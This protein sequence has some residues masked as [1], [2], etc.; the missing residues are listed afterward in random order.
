[1]L[2]VQDL[3]T[4]DSIR[5]HFATQG[6]TYWAGVVQR[7][8]ETLAPASLQ[9]PDSRAAV[10]AIATIGKTPGAMPS[11]PGGAYIGLPRDKTPANEAASVDGKLASQARVLPGSDF[12]VREG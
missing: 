8:I 6:K 10:P 5:L 7:A 2:T 4:L 12:G 1:M 3:M 11:D 9:Q